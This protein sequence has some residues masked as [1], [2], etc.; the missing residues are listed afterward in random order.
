MNR[1]LHRWE[2]ERGLESLYREPTF[3]IRRAHQIA[4]A[5]FARSC[6]KL[7]LT[8][9]QYSVL[10]ALRHVGPIGQNHLGR[11][12]A[13]DRCTTSLVVRLLVERALIDRVNDPV[14]GRK[15]KLS[16]NDSGRV[17]LNRAE[18]LATRASRKLLSVLDDS[19]TRAFMSIL[20]KFTR[21]HQSG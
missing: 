5:T 2:T 18:R 21:A 9:S 17:L 13:L 19:Q 20:D 4:S 7:D 12:V 11:L 16:L 1:R 3:M 10:F 8:P 14:D 6:V 15:K